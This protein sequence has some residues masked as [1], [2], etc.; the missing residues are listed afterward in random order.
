LLCG[1]R[2]VSAKPPRKRHYGEIIDDPV[3]PP[4]Y[5]AAKERA[6]KIIERRLKDD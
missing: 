5:D 3:T 6:R 1:E 2:I 4:D